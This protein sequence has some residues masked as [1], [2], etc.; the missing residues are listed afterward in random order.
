MSALW[1]NLAE[2]LRVNA[3][4][5]ADR[6]ALKDKSRLLTFSQL[7]TRI[8]KLSNAM[9]GLGLKKGD[10]VSCLLENCLE[11]IE[12]YLACARTGIVINPINFRLSPADVAYIAA[13][14]DSKAFF[15]HDEFIPL[16]EQ[17]K[18]Q[19]PQIKHYIEIKSH[20]PHSKSQISN[21]S[22]YESWLNSAPD[23]DPGIRVDP[24]DTWVLLYTSGTTG[25]PK[26][27]L[28]SHESYIAFYLINA[29][30][31]SFRPDDIC[32]NVMPL[33][34][35]NTTYFSFTFTYIGGGIYVHPARNF[36]PEEILGIVAREKATFISLIPTHYNLILGLPAD[37]RAKYD[38]SSINKLLCSSAPARG[39]IKK[40]VMEYF[41][42]ARLY[43][44]YG[45]TEAG[46]V[47]ILRP[48]EQLSKAGSIGKESIGTDRIKILD[49]AGKELPAG[50]VGEL[51]SRGPMLFDGYYKLPDKTKSVFKGQWFSAGDM[52]KKDADGYYYLVDRKDNMIITGGEHVYP[53]EVE[54][55]LALN[56]KVFESAV[57]GVPD[58]KWGE[59]VKAFI[60]LK[61]G[62]TS[63]EREIIDY[64]RDKMAAYKKPKS[65]VFIKSVDIPRTA[66]G[67]T[68]YRELRGKYA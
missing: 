15:V 18:P 55:A 40:R 35:V 16:I 41:T 37:V 64:C 63:T 53:S 45:S 23:K 59:S 5:Y 61:E 2:T 43:E 24:K 47:T 46:I 26:G 9:L 13:D 10:K 30:D 66:S 25:K 49:S 29:G 28:R 32:L 6:M 52:A 22:D 67:K 11:I 54:E 12:L 65:V 34:H 51:Y 27:V 36:N 33:C 19:L 20:I 31:F 48:E 14:A 60:V 68:L 50:Q 7:N 58:D 8:D 1:L 57:I 39:E 44:G 17:I 38:V 42:N 62:Q 4:K 21:L 56:P 3:A